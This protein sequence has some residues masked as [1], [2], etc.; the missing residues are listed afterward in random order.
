M[1][2]NKRYIYNPFFVYPF[3]VWLVVGGYLLANY[4]KEY[5]FS[6]VNSRHT[7]F[8]DDLMYGITHFGQ[9]ET[10]IPL[11]LFLLVFPSFRN[12][13]YVATALVCNLVPMF[14][15]QGMKAWFDEPR[16]LKYF[17]DA[18]WIHKL[19][20]WPS[21]YHHSFPSGHTEGAFSFFC[22]LSLLLYPSHRPWA[23]LFFLLAL[24][25]GYSRMYLAAH[26]FADV[27]VGSMVGFVI[28]TLCF[29]FMNEYLGKKVKWAKPL[30]HG[31]M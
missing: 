1:G 18:D 31:I 17:S 27:Y 23:T 30:Q 14:T 28:T 11:L 8:L 20:H 21:L 12:W 22:F 29:L 9:A 4:S 15:Q 26:F 13:W 6:F 10:V 16:P 25:V 5:L 24:L 3:L 2:K 19:P 7:P